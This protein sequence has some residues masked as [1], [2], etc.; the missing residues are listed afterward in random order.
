MAPP[1]KKARTRGGPK[2]DPADEQSAGILTDF[3]TSW[4]LKYAHLF[5]PNLRGH[6]NLALGNK[7]H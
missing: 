6:S 7:S 4:L 5:H 3:R 1:R 2:D